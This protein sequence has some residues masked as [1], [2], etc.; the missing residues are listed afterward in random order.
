MAV[1]WPES[2]ADAA[3]NSLNVAIHG[4]RQTLRTVAG[5]RPIVICKEHSYFIEPD[6]GIWVDVEAFEERL[7]SAEQHLNTDDAAQAQTDFGRRTDRP[8]WLMPSLREPLP[9]WLGSDRC[10]ADPCEVS[11]HLSWYREVLPGNRSC[12]VVL[13]PVGST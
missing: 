10:R 3:R 7:K 5:D 1:F 12:R 4:L 8:T 9:S 2:T 13:I 6:L 11:V